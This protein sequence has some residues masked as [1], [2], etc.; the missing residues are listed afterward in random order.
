MYS[1]NEIHCH[2]WPK[3]ISQI[4]KLKQFWKSLKIC[5][6]I[7]KKNGIMIWMICIL[8]LNQR[9]MYIRT[10]RYIFMLIILLTV[11]YNFILSTNMPVRCA[12]QIWVNA[13]SIKLKIVMKAS[14][15]DLCHTKYKR[16]SFSR[17]CYII[18]KRKE[19]TCPWVWYSL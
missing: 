7:I 8:L 19:I 1:T 16:K 14:C 11:V 15:W 13:H 10:C 4:I 17:C 12:H 2:I 6:S 9:C 18:L 3:N 5:H